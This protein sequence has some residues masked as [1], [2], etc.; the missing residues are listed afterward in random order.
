MKF[1]YGETGFENGGRFRP[2]KTHANG[3][4]V[5]FFVPV[6]DNAKK[7]TTLN[8]SAFNKL[9]YKIEFDQSASNADYS[10]DFE[11]IAKHLLAIHEAAKKDKIGIRVVIF[12]NDFQNILFKT[13]SG[14][15][16]KKIMYFSVKKPWVRHDEHY[17]IDFIVKC[18]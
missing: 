17:H 2:H 18:H 15:D 14:K 3:T 1:I 6:L 9:G 7:S 5:D 16:L 10:I 8:I 4:S 13:K 11:S 12:D